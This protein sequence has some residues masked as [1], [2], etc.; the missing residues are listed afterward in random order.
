MN[1]YALFFV[2]IFSTGA[3]RQGRLAAKKRI[4]L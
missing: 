4:I 1:K 3:L 2:D